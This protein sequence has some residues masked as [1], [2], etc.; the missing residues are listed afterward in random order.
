MCLHRCLPTSCSECLAASN[1]SRPLAWCDKSKSL[2]ACFQ[3][4]DFIPLILVG[5][6]RCLFAGTES[7][8]TGADA[9]GEGAV[10]IAQ[11]PYVAPGRQQQLTL[12]YVHLDVSQPLVLHVLIKAT[13]GVIMVSCC[14]SCCAVLLRTDCRGLAG[15]GS[16]C[17]K[18]G[19]CHGEETKVTERYVNP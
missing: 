5:L 14:G 16:V 10:T 2:L 4:K 13:R 11:S 6:S 17:T 8:C 3:S 15:T 19:Q 18:T 12:S 1:K 7:V 9:C